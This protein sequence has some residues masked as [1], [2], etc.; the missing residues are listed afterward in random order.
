MMKSFPTRGQIER[1]KLRE[2]ERHRVIMETLESDLRELQSRCPHA[3]VVDKVC[4]DC[5]LTFLFVGE[6]REGSDR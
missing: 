5:G 4:P 6:F 1:S 2:I 3:R